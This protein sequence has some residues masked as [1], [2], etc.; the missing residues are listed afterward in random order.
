MKEL[1]FTLLVRRQGEPTFT[2][3]KFETEDYDTTIDL[4]EDIED[5]VQSI[6]A[7]EREWQY[8][9]EGDNED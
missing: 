2:S 8:R 3:E 7:D 4:I 5:F 9:N 6:I 1:R